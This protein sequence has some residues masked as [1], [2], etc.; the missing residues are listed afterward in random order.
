MIFLFL[1]VLLTVSLT[2]TLLTSEA[3][4]IRCGEAG[5]AGCS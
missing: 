4:E 5:F 2:C 3:H 1:R